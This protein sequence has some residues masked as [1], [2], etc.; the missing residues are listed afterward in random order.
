M[1][2]TVAVAVVAFA[3]A[4]ATLAAQS[5]AKYAPPRT[6]WGDPDLQGTWPGTDLVGTPLQRDPKYGTRNVLTEDEFQTRK[7]QFEK[8]LET[9]NADFDPEHPVGTPGDVGSP[10]SPPPH[11]LERGQ[12]QHIASLIVD[13]PDGRMPPTTAEAQQRNA[14]AAAGRRGGRPPESWTDLSLYD[15][16]ITRGVAGSM[17]P[18]IYNN[19][20]EILQAPGLVVLRNEMIH[21]TRV[22][23]L[24]GRPHPNAAVTLWMGDSRGHFDGD[25]L[26]VETTNFDPRA[27]GVGPNGGGRISGALTIVEHITR[28]A[29]DRLVWRMTFEDPKT[30]TRPFTIELPLR[31]DDNYGMFEYACHEGNY[32]LRNILS[33]ARADERGR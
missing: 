24:D 13:P 33:A 20:N 25:T 26:V 11:W 29:A 1:K 2:K 22:V 10:T 14:A 31:R 16:C 4:L 7:A 27:P 6:P 19:G 15:R 21:E 8:Q 18:V 30:W 32:A 17:L 3:C 23:Y 28:V 12:P 9:D 5:P